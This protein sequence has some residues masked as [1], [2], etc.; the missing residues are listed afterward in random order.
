MHKVRQHVKLLFLLFEKIFIGILSSIV[1]K[2]FLS[3]NPMSNFVD[4]NTNIKIEESKL[5]VWH[6]LK[7]ETFNN[8][9]HIGSSSRSLR[10]LYRST[11]NT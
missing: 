1:K 6:L 7:N 10:T 4:E 5:T 9:T 2:K 8:G 3:M 11:D